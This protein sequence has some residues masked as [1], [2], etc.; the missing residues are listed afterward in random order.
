MMYIDIIIPEF[1]G[2]IVDDMRDSGTITSISAKQ[3]DGTYIIT[4]TNSTLAVVNDYII[5]GTYTD[6]LVTAKNT[7]TITVKPINTTSFT[8]TLTTWTTAKPYFEYGNYTEI[9][10]IIAEKTQTGAFKFQKYPMVCLALPANEKRFSNGE[11]P[12]VEVSVMIIIVT[13]T[14]LN[15]STKQR[16]AIT[17]KPIL[18]PLYNK[19]MEAL[20]LNRSLFIMEPNEGFKHDKMDSWLFDSDGTNKNK[21]NDYTD[22]IVIS[23]LALNIHLQPTIPCNSFK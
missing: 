12:G 6:L 21:F 16:I 19:L 22:A 8:G 5:I 1:I 18:Y 2:A 9:C 23:N 14:E 17:G 3:S 15:Y 11:L 7:T 13:E 4:A 10:K 20:E